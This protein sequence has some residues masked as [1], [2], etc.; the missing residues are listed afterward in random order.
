M[1]ITQRNI[2]ISVVLFLTLAIG[3]FAFA[4]HI[5]EIED[6]YGDLQDF[7][8][9]SK[10]GDLI[11]FGDYEKI[12]KVNK[13]WKRIKVID[14]DKDTVDLYNWFNDDNYSKGKMK[15]FRIKKK[16]TLHEL[17]K[18]KIQPKIHSGEIRQ[19]FSIKKPL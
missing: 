6:Q 10:S 8:Y 2:F 14:F 5:M 9:K 3:Y 17:K 15:L 18:E 4:F 1:T 13:T 12:G 16:I 11:I 19:V 7:Y